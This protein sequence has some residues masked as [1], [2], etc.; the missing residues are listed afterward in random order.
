M[1]DDG[2]NELDELDEIDELDDV[3][4]AR[5]RT[6]LR[7]VLLH[8]QRAVDVVPSLLAGLTND[9]RR[10]VKDAVFGVAVQRLR[11]L[12]DRALSADDDALDDAALD[13]LVARLH[14]PDDGPWP[15]DVVDRLA[16]QRSCPRWLVQRLVSSLGVDDADRFL[17]A[18]N[19]PGPRTL[20]ANTIV[21]DRAGLQRA[22]ADEAI[23]VVDSPRTPWAV[24][25]VG[26]ANL[27]GCR[28]FRDGRFEVQDASSQAVVVAAA[29]RPGDVVVDLCAGRGGK[30]LA[31]AAAMNDRGTLWF[32]DVDGR[33]LADLRGRLPRARVTCARAGLPDDGTA[34]VVVVDAPCS[35]VG[36]L[37][38]SPDLRF[39]L[40]PDDVL[41][42]GSVQR[43]LLAQA[44]RLVRPGGRV[45]YAT[46][47]VLSD[48]NDG[49]VNAVLATI[50]WLVARSRTLLVPRVVD[51]GDGFFVAL[52]ERTA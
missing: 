47:S 50:P 20:R 41:A 29:V 46:C 28:A 27:F 7:R 49:V 10:A 18:S 23:V 33:A 51:D 2:I 42:L 4:T 44:A 17:Q 38:R 40:S 19:Q 25:V 13:E 32:H 31:L 14:A 8:G 9:Q 36:V 1:P 16:V 3:V 45:V 34:D 52:L 6:G 21:N 43:A 11:L 22:L 24:D 37:R 26:R 35:S 30:T 48:E 39:S 15:D 12:R 5:N